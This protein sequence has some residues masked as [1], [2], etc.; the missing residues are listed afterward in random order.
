MEG[1]SMLIRAYKKLKNFVQGLYHPFHH[2]ISHVVREH[3][4]EM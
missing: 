2:Y 4:S 1:M 3:A